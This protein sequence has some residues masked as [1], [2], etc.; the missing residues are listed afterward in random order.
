VKNAINSKLIEGFKKVSSTTLSDIFDEMDIN[1]NII[2]L[3]PVIPGVK[4]VGAAVTVKA[5]TGIKGTYHRSDFGKVINLFE[6]VRKG[7]VVVFDNMGVPVSGWGGL[8]S[9]AMKQIGVEGLVMDGGVRDIDEIK[10][11]GFQVY[12]RFFTPRS[13]QTRVKIDSI[14]ERIQCCGVH[15]NPGDIIVG[16]STSI[17]VVP[18]STAESILE[19]AIELEEKE[20]KIRSEL[21]KGLSFREASA[22]YARI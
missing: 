15:V 6:M 7:D 22:K 3:N 12:A 16:D 20:E 17:A 13:A 19:K 14:N 5:V 11:S 21:M 1:G 8:A 4:I 18:L 10:E 2:G 9:V